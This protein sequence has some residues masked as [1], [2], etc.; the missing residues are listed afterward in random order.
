VTARFALAT[1]R[2]ALTTARI[3][4]AT[5]KISWRRVRTSFALVYMP[6][7]IEFAAKE[8]AESL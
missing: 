3:A 1:A 4:L 5:A 6:E 2:I 8:K 7:T